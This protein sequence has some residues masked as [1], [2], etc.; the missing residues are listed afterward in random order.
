MDAHTWRRSDTQLQRHR[1]TQLQRHR[2]RHTDTDNACIYADTER[3]GN[4]HTDTEAHRK[5][6][7]DIQTQ[8]LRHSECRH[9][10]TD[11]QTQWQQLLWENSSGGTSAKEFHHLIPNSAMHRLLSN[12]S[13][14]SSTFSECV[15][16]LGW[17]PVCLS[18]YV[19]VCLTVYVFA[20]LFVSRCVCLSVYVF[21]CLPVHLSG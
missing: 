19:F 11:K 7:T 16:L 13:Q 2:E 18:V 20:C 14:S 21:V 12:D 3:Q 17:L 8:R 4:G 5:I 15:R 1:P 6:E 9:K 10:E